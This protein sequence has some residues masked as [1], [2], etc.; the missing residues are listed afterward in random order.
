MNTRIIKKIYRQEIINVTEFLIEFI[1]ESRNIEL[2]NILLECLDGNNSPE[3][4]ETLNLYKNFLICISKTNEQKKY[5][6]LYKNS[7]NEIIHDLLIEKI[8]KNNKLIGDGANLNLKIHEY[9]KMRNIQNFTRTK[10]IRI[11]NSSNP[12]YQ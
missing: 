10:K 7:N 1:N 9:I 6:E 4:E 11:N 5:V 3:A 12:Y 2:E 8:V